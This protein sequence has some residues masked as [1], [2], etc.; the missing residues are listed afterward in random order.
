MFPL[1]GSISGDPDD[2][3]W[4]AL[5]QEA[6]E[7]D[8]IV[9]DDEP[10]TGDEARQGVGACQ[11]HEREDDGDQQKH[12]SGVVV[13]EKRLSYPAIRHSQPPWAE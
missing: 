9:Q 12:G 11:G 8:E 10:T 7:R 2:G 3:R 4:L 5:Q 13:A 1:A 6:R